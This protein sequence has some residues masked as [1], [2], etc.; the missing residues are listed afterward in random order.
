MLLRLHEPNLN[1]TVWAFIPWFSEYSASI[2]GYWPFA[3][4]RRWN[5]TESP[6][7]LLFC[8]STTALPP[9]RPGFLFFR[10]LDIPQQK[11]KTVPLKWISICKEFS[12]LAHKSENCTV[13]PIVA[14]GKCPTTDHVGYKRLWK[15]PLDVNC[16]LLTYLSAQEVIL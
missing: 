9:S 7:R 12:G 2:S 4:I 13:L 10:R 15:A 16:G 8:F 1:C 5:N 3:P 11:K 14:Y 6:T